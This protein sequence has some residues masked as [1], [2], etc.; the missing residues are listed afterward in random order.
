MPNKEKT[1]GNVTLPTPNLRDYFAG[2]ALS[3][4]ILKWH[5]DNIGFEMKDYEGTAKMSYHFADQMLKAR[6]EK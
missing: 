5:V 4:L 6:E 2:Q 1:E 3:G